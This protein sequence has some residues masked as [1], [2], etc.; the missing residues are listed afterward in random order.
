[1]RNLH[2]TQL[3][4]CF[5]SAPHPLAAKRIHTVQE[6]KDRENREATWLAHPGNPEQR[7]AH[8]RNS[9][10]HCLLREKGEERKVRPRK[11]S[12]PRSES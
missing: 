1:M 3:T 11:V 6:H 7:L 10:I 8:C 4:H 2:G 12:C 5:L 9:Q